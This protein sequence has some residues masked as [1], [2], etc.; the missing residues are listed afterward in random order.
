MTKQE[1]KAVELQAATA[2]EINS[3][4]TM[5]Q[6]ENQALVEIN[7]DMQNKVNK[8][9]LVM[10]TLDSQDDKDV[11]EIL[12]VA[13]RKWERKLLVNRTRMATIPTICKF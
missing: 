11:I 7:F 10:S 12:V 5:T 2:L 1:I 6:E 9:K 3:K 4:A 13:T 8:A